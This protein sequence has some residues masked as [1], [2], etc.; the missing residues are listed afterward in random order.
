[1]MNASRP[2]LARY[3][4]SSQLI[5]VWTLVGYP[6][7]KTGCED[8]R[9]FG[10]EPLGFLIYSPDGF[11]S[12]QLMKP[13]RSA[14]QSPDWRRGTPEEFMAK[15]MGATVRSVTSRHASLVSHS[16]EVAAN[17]N[18]AVESGCAVSAKAARL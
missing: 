10:P 3:T 12:A 1:M 7:E 8:A 4:I 16:T 2:G 17:V 14:F 9:P 6:Y 15:R 13:G 18:P 11:V 5:G